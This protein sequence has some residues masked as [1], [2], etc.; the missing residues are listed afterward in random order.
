MFNMKA[1]LP[2][3]ALVACVS[4]IPIDVYDITINGVTYDQNAFIRQGNLYLAPSLDILIVSGNPPASPEVGA[5][6]FT[7]DRSFDVLLD[8]ALSFSALKLAS[9]VSDNAG[10]VTYTVDERLASP[11]TSALNVMNALGGLTAGI[12]YFSR[13]TVVITYTGQS[14]KG[15]INM[16]GRSFSS[17]Y[18]AHYE[19][20]FS[21]DRVRTFEL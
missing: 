5:I 12:Y 3:L 20:T 8:D 18:E 1:I 11:D 21:G 4:C 2:F 7:S 16:F 13:G 19:A 10:T 9:V 14:L 17:P 15:K 6:W